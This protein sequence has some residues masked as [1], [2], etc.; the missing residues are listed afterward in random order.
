[1]EPRD[2]APWSEDSLTSIETRQVLDAT[3]EYYHDHNKQ[4]S[5]DITIDEFTGKARDYHRTHS[6]ISVN[7]N[8]HSDTGKAEESVVVKDVVSGN[9]SPSPK[10]KKKGSN[11]GS[12]KFGRGSTKEKKKK[13]SAVTESNGHGVDYYNRMHSSPT[14]GDSGARFLVGNG[15]PRDA[16]AMHAMCG[17]TSAVAS[18]GTGLLW[19]T[20]PAT[21]NLASSSKFLELSIDGDPHIKE[22]TGL[23][24]DNPEVFYTPQESDEDCKGAVDS[25][26]EGSRFDTPH[27]SE[28]GDEVSRVESESNHTEFGQNR[29]QDSA[30]PPVNGSEEKCERNS[31][32]NQMDGKRGVFNDEAHGLLD[33]DNR[34]GNCIAVASQSDML[35]H[36]GEQ[37][38]SPERNCANHV[39]TLRNGLH[40][41]Q[42]EEIEQPS[43]IC[44]SDVLQNLNIVKD[45]DFVQEDGRAGSL[46]DDEG[47]DDLFLSLPTLISS[48]KPL[49]TFPKQ[50]V[51]RSSSEELLS[52]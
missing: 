52:T 31:I 36:E 41:V 9:H 15:F 16:V 51:Q 7:L 33:G 29:D 49:T 43:G 8:P 38:D 40:E 45:D 46:S 50:Q 6:T 14:L 25:G 37:Q 1:M 4:F 10:T 48:S 44:P 5:D 20:V 3:T 47:S 22:D 19:Q 18:S 13:S 35:T 12:F 23:E 34:S 27:E 42:N 32:M 30:G 24:V 26:N 39:D 11:R 28:S 17:D 21:L 2:H